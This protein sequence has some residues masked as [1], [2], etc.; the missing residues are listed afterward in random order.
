MSCVASTHFLQTLLSAPVA[1]ILDE[2]LQITNRVRGNFVWRIMGSHSWT[3]WTNWHS[4]KALWKLSLKSETLYSKTDSYFWIFI[5]QSRTV[6][7]VKSW[8]MVHGPTWIDITHGM[9]GVWWEA[10]SC[11]RCHELKGGMEWTEYL[12]NSHQYEPSW[13]RRWIRYTGVESEALMNDYL[14]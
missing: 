2:I 4:C 3:N 1:F 14:I 5:I 7:V 10:V 6:T 9:H 8:K 11:Q 13:W 12:D